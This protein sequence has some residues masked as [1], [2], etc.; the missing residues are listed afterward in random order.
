[1]GDGDR[2]ST[3]GLLFEV[4]GAPVCW[5]TGKQNTVA[6]SS[7]EAGYVALS[8]TAAELLWLKFLLLDL[9]VEINDPMV[10]FEDYQTCI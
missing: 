7:T 5:V 8:N 2:K 9:K 1:M 3:S 4:Y 6:V 10:I